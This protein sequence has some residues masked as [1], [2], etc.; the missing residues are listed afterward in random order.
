MTVKEGQGRVDF[1][2]LYINDGHDLPQ[3]LIQKQMEK[4]RRKSRPLAI[5]D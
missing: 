2:V 3:K 1:E 4:I 5:V